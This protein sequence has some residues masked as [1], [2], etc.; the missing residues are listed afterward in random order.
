MFQASA[1]HNANMLS[2]SVTHVGVGAAIGPDGN[3][4]ICQSFVG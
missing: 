1:G 4:Y 2:A 3:V